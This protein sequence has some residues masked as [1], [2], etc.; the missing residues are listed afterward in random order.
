MKTIQFQQT[1]LSLSALCLAV[2]TATGQALPPVPSDAGGA[3]VPNLGMHRL[4]VDTAG[5]GFL[6]SG[7][8]TITPPG[9]IA[10]SSALGTTT[11]PGLYLPDVGVDTDIYAFLTDAEFPQDLMFSNTDPSGSLDG[12]AVDGAGDPI[13]FNLLWP[14]EIPESTWISDMGLDCNSPTNDLEN[15]LADIVSTGSKA[16]VEEGLDILLGTNFSGAL[17]NKA[18]KGYELLNYKGRKDNQ[19]WDPVTRNITIEQLWFDNEI[20]SD[21][22][23]VKVPAD[24]DYTIT[25]KLR[26][27]GDIGADRKKAFIIDEF[28]AIPMKTTSN[29]YFWNRNAWIWKW[30]GIVGASDGS[31]RKFMLEDLFAAHTGTD[32]APSYADISPPNPQYWLHADRKFNLGSYHG[33]N[34]LDD[35]NDRWETSDLDMSGSIGGFLVDGMD[36]GSPYDSVTNTAAQFNQYGNNEYVVP[37][38]DWSQGPYLIPHFGYDS[39]FTT[40][41]KGKATDVTVRYGQGMNQAGIYIWGWRVH[42]PR[43]NWIESYSEGQ[44]LASGAPKDWRFGHKWDAVAGLG[45]DALGDHSPEKVIYNALLTFDLSSGDSTAVAALETSVTGMVDHIRDR[46]GLPPTEDIL[47]FPNA[48]SDLNLL[49]SNLDI[50]GDNDTLGSSGKRLWEEGDVLRVTIHNDEDFTRFFRAVDFGTTDYQYNGVDMGRLDWKPVFGFPQFAANAW[51]GLFGVQ[52]FG[53]S[54][55]AGSD[56]DGTG[57]PFF[58]D[59]AL[60]FGTDHLGLFSSLNFAGADRDIQHAYDDL[61]GFSGPGFHALV[62]GGIEP[63]GNNLLAGKPTGTPNIWAYAYGKPIPAHTTVTFDIETPRSAGLNNGALYMFDPQFHYSSIWTMH[64]IAEKIPEGLQD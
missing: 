51:A 47:D 39:T 8:I 3:N 55:W 45:V 54:F 38:V 25:W 36:T 10:P 41:R 16:R 33:K 2:S 15:V 11:V 61:A 7:A 30:F 12:T 43:I 31:G 42:P 28:S 22:N 63:W 32:A 20:R 29:T 9:A 27:L 19:T 5:V 4:K 48:S 37:M 18:Y 56:L 24:G 23:M 62:G 64:P 46:R 58:V 13:H 53:N 17:S 6:Q 35:V 52:G 59:P 26:G 44:M 21:S 40:V 14:Q 50:F 60:P 34:Q 57:N 1:L 49:Y